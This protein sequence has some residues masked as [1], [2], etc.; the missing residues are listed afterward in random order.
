MIFYAS[1][2][3]MHSD[4]WHLG[5]VAS[6]RWR[7]DS[8]GVGPR[9]RWNTVGTEASVAATCFITK[10]THDFFRCDWHFVDADAHRI[11]DGIRD[12]G[13]NRQQGSLAHLLRPVW[14]IR[15]RIF[16]QV[17]LDVAHLHRRRTLVFQ[18][19]WKLRSEEHTSE[20]QSPCNL[21][22]RLLL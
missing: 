11:V 14:S 20:L 22:C 17:R 10:S 19:R 4:V 6:F 3:G 13:W 18:H 5:A 8:Q 12:G 2:L 21:V 7:Q 1:I 15:I 9:N 16:D